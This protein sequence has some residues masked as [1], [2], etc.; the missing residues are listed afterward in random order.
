MTLSNNLVAPSFAL[1]VLINHSRLYFST[2]AILF[3]VIILERL[4]FFLKD[5]S[6]NALQWFLVQA[7]VLPCSLILEYL[8]LRFV[9]KKKLKRSFQQLFLLIF[10]ICIV[11]LVVECTLK[12]TNISTNSHPN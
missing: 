8:I 10:Q 3:L 11:Q 12:M 9:S 7:I 2:K 5:N 1:Q 4:G 6:K